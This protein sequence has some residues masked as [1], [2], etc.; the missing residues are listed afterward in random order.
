MLAGRAHRSVLT[1]CVMGRKK[2]LE[3]GSAADLTVNPDMSVGL[4]DDSI[5]RGQTETRAASGLFRR[6]EGLEHVSTNVVR[7]SNARVLHR[8]HDIVAG[9]D[10]GPRQ[11]AVSGADRD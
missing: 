7:H 4:T 5:H 10:D 6:E 1:G 9:R 11:T 8:E 3:G 2:D